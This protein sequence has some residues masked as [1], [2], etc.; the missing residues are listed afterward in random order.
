MVQES[1]EAL[2]LFGTS[3]CYRSAGRGGPLLNIP[4]SVTG[5][6]RT[7]PRLLRFSRESL[8]G[9]RKC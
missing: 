8:C 7:D 3:T 5:V 1:I 9:E 6:C 4:L 2:T